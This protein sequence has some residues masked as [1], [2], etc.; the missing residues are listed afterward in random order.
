ME[1]PPEVYEALGELYESFDDGVFYLE[2]ESMVR[3]GDIDE[4]KRAA[5]AW[6]ILEK[7]R[8]G[9]LDIEAIEQDTGKYIAS[10]LQHEP[11]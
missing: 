11:T 6:S 7:W 4:A 9:G 8:Y 5:R 10:L 3:D 1:M 2:I